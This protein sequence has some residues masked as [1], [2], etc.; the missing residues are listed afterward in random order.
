MFLD[1]KIINLLFKNYVSFIDDISKEYDYNDNIKHLLYIIVPAFVAKY[2][3]NN[4]PTILKCFKNVKIYIR[5]HNENVTAAFNRS[6]KKGS[7]GYYTEKF[8]TVSPFNDSSLSSILD[9][10]IHEFNHAINSV[11]NEIIVTD[12]LIKVRTGLSTLNYEKKDMTFI[13]KSNETV[14]EELL[15]TAQ[16][17]DVINIIRS[18]S[19]YNIEN[20]EISN[21][22]YN[23]DKELGEENYTSN[24]YKFQKQVCD[25]LINNKTFIPTANKLRLKGTTEDI[26]EMFDNVIGEKGSYEKL[27]DLLTEMYFE[28]IKYGNSTVL[29]NKYLNK[30]KALT[31]EVSK[32]IIDYNNKCIFR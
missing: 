16:S 18:F 27:N 31:N 19:K 26:P 32:L 10:L 3:V 7:D 21:A 14:L 2:G 23:I 12:D 29:K 11:N 20:L 24:A 15:N 4:E 22:I 17:E 1:Q 6:L 8:I 5:E 25:V 28:I 9:N 30:I 13:E